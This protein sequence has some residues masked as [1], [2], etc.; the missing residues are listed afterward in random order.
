[1]VI[2]LT[3]ARFNLP[4]RKSTDAYAGFADRL[5]EACDLADI[6]GGRARNKALSLRFDV[7]KEAV[8]Q[9]FKGQAFPETARLAKV[10]DEF[11]CSL[12]WLIL[13]RL[14][15]TGQVREPGGAYKV[16]TEQERA[17]ITAMRKLN[18]RRRN[19]LV[20]LLADSEG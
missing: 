13:G 15:S 9:W 14:P 3:K 20:Q 4:T 1:L 11:E 16:L 6:P 7:S 17:V 5:K 19:A 2:G 12:D 10:A 8:R 18:A